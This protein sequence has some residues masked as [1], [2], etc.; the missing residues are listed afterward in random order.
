MRSL[1]A[2]REISFVLVLV[3]VAVAAQRATA[4]APA[5]RYAIQNDGTALDTK[6]GL[7]WQREVPSQIYNWTD[8]GSYCSNNTP[9]LPGSGW[10]L[11]SMKELQ[12][13]VDDSRFNPAIDPTV[14]PATPSER[15]WTSSAS[16]SYGRWVV[17]F[18]SGDALPDAASTTRRVRCVR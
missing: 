10:R 18:S 11:P 14:F 7:T 3:G 15:F 17:D 8:A 12:T 9:G 1:R 4:D 2:R 5:G 13:I 16:P 6:T